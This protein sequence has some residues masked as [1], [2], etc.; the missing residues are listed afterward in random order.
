MHF[1]I[2]SKQTSKTKKTTLYIYTHTHTINMRL[3]VSIP[4]RSRFPLF[5]AAFY[6]IPSFP[7]HD[8][9]AVHYTQHSQACTRMQ[10]TWQISTLHEHTNKPSSRVY[11]ANLSVFILAVSVFAHLFPHASNSCTS[12]SFLSFSL[13]LSPRSPCY[14]ST[15]SHFKSENPARHLTSIRFA[16]LNTFC[17]YLFRPKSVF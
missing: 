17:E 8:S 12:H 16:I 4:Y 15:N 3:Q 5:P 9:L 1:I 6:Q 13:S 11:L 2:K 7:R 10:T 14:L